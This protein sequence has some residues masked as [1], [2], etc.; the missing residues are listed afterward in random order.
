M[1][2]RTLV[3]G[4]AVALVM[5]GAPISPVGVASADGCGI[6]VGSGVW[7]APPNT[8]PV[9]DVSHQAAGEDVRDVDCQWP[10]CGPR[11]WPANSLRPVR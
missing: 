3:A 9:I 10:R 8:A 2:I 1:K 7:C 11:W 6:G 4:L 5:V